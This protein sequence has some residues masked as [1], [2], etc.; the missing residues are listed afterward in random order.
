[1]KIQIQSIHFDANK[2]LQNFVHDKINKV[3]K[4]FNKIESCN[5]LLKLD[6]NDKTKNK[7]VEIRMIIPGHRLF[8]SDRSETFEMATDMAVDE[9]EKQLH[10]HKNKMISHEIPSDFRTILKGK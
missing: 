8:A 6:K 9:I 4:I 2:K 3:D 7:V 1:M 5:A 10:K